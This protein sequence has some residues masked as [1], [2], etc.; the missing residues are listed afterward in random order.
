MSKTRMGKRVAS[1]LLSLV[2][3]LSLLPTTVYAEGADDVATYDAVVEETI[4]PVN[5]E[6]VDAVA[7]EAESSGDKVSGED[8]DANVTEGGGTAN[9]RE[10]ETEYAAFSGSTY[11]ATLQDAINQGPYNIY[12]AKDVRE[13]FSIP[14]GKTVNLSLY[15]HQLHGAITNDGSL[16]IDQHKQYYA[17]PDIGG[18]DAV[19]TNNGTL[20]LACDGATAF[21]V[22]N[23][24]TLNITSGA[25]YSVSNITNN[26]DG[27]ITISGGYF[28]EAPSADWMPAYYVAKQQTNGRYK[29]V[30]M[31][32]ADAIAAGY[33]A[34][35][36]FNG[37]S[38]YK[39]VQE[40]I[41][42]LGYSSTT[43]NLIA[44]VTE[45]C[46]KADGDISLSCVGTA[47]FTGSL[48]CPGNI[49]VQNGTVTLNNIECKSFTAQS[50]SWNN[51]T[52][53]T[54]KDGT[55]E[56]VTVEKTA[57]NGITVAIEGGSYTGTV[58]VASEG[59]LTVTGGNF[60][61]DVSAYLADGYTYD[62][63]TGTVTPA[64]TTAAAKIGETTYETLAEAFAAAKDGD[65]ITLLRDCSGDGIGVKP[66]TFTS[67][68]L[69]VDFAGHT[70][71]VG[72]KLV[73]SSGTMSNGFQL[74]KNNK[75]TFQNGAIY[76][77]AS[78]AGDDTTS[79]S[80][81]PAIL[82]Q[83]Y[84]D[85][86]LS[87]MK[88]SGGSNTVY[89]M[90]NN[91]GNVVIENTTI[92]AG[93]GSSGRAPFALDACGY[94][95]YTGVSVTVKGTSAINGDIEVSRGAKNKN[96]VTLT[97]E[98][99]TVNGK[100]KIDSSI[101]SGDATTVT[102]SNAVN[103]AAPAG[104]VWDNGTLAAAV[105]QI[106]E[107]GYASLQAAID[108]AKTGDT[109]TLLADATEDVTINKNITLDLG[110]KTL[111]NTNAGKATI[112]VTGGTVTVK[113]GTVIGGTSYYNIEV[114]KGSNANLTLEG[115]TATAGN[116]GSSMIDNWGTL[117][118]ESGDY[119]GGMNTV[120]SEEGSTLTINGGTFTC[121]FGK[122]WSYTAVILVYGDTTINGGKFIQKTTNTSS[123]AKV[124]M[125]G[126]EDGYEA[127]TKVTGGEF[128]NEKL[129]GIFWALGK[130]TPDNFEVSGGTFNKFVSDSFFKEG[131]FAQKNTDGTYGVGG[132]AVAKVNSAEGYNT[133]AEAI[134]AAKAGD[135][136][137]LLQNVTVDK[138]I[139]VDKAITLDLGGKTLTSTW[140]MPSD[141]SG[142]DRYALVNNAKMTLTNGTFA[143]DQARAI[144]AYAGL[145]LN[146]VIVSQTM[147]G[148]HACVAFCKA[149]AT[150]TIKS[151]TITGDY[152]VANFANNATI[153]ITNSTKL[154]G[155]TCGLYHNGSNYGLKLTVINTTINGSLDGTIGNENDPSGVYISGSASHGTMQKAT[156]TNC[157][158]KGATAIEVKYTDLT[159][160]K[161]TV[162]AT[163]KTPSY[164]KNNNGMTALG[165]AVVSTDNSKDGVTPVPAGTVTIKGKGNYTGLVGLGALKSVK[166]TYEGFTD[167]TIKVS[168][169]TF[170]NTVL[171]EYCADGFIPT[172]NADG[173]YGV[174]QGTYVAET[175]GVKYESL[176]EAITAAK[177]GATVKL[178]ADTRENVTIAND[179]TLDLNGHT[180]NGGTE[181][182][183]PALTV[184]ASVNVMTRV[185]V[186]DSSEAQT[187][188]IM[189]EDTAENSGVSSHYVIDIQGKCVL[190][191]E[192]GNVKN[193]SGNKEGKGASLVRVG[194]DSNMEVTPFLTIT[195]G[196]FTQNNFIAIKVDRGI[197]NLSGGEVNSANSYAVE[198]WCNANIKGGIVNGT[199]STW[200]YSKGAATSKLTIIDGTVK[201]DVASVNYDS[202][203]DKQARVFIEGG[204]V[205]GTLGTYT[206]NNG[207][208]A[209][210]ETS[211]ATIKV[212]GGTFANA[213]E[214]Q[215]C[216][217]GYVP[218]EN[219]DNTYGVQKQVLAKIG[220]I[221]YYTMG[222]AFQAVREGETIVMQRDY[223]TGAEQSS[224]NK[225]FAIDLNGKTWTYTGT[226][227]NHAAFEINYPNVTL[228]V[229]N[230]TVVSN[231]M[232]GLIPSAM[233]G[234]ITYD[235]AGLVFE[236]VKMTAKGHSGI[237]TNGSN[238]SDTVT[239][240]NSTL[241]VPNGFGIY[242]PSSGKLTI[243]NS[244]ITAKTMGVQVCAGSLSISGD[245]T[246]ITV[247]GDAV[248]KTENDG[249]IQD[250]AAISIVNRT[251]YKGLGDVT[252]TGGTFTAKTGNEAIKAYDWKNNTESE[253]ADAGKYIN[254][255][256]GTFSSIP[257]NM[258]ALCEDG[259]V[260]VKNA[261]G[262]AVQTGTY[263]ASI[264]TKKFATLAEAVEAAKNGDTVK[265]LGDVVLG[266]TLII[267]DK[268]ITLDLNGRIISNSADIWDESK[269]AWSLI[270][271]RDKGNLTIDD[272]TG[273][274]TL[275][276][277]END[278]F[279]LDVYAYDTK[280]VEN[281]KLTINA[282]N[283]VGNISAVYAFTGKATINGGHF[284]I[285]QKEN[286]SDPYRLTLNCYD[287]SYTAGRAGFTVNGGTFENFDPRNNKAEGAG[288]S[289]V[290]EGVGVNNENGTF[291][292]V[293]NMAAQRIAADGSSV[294]AYATLADAIA[295]AQ[296]GQTVMLLA[297]VNGNVEIAA[298]KNLTLDLNGK[299]LNGGTGT[300]KAA[301]RNL[302]TITI[303]DTSAD[304]TGTIKRDDNGT[305]GG[306]SYYVIDNQGTMTIES[307][308]VSNNSGYRKTNPS[309]SMVGSSLIRNG[310]DTAATLTITGGTLEQKNFIAIKNGSLGTLNVSGGTISSDHSAIQNWFVANIT[311]GKI[312]GQLWTD[313][314]EEGESVGKTT[315]GENAKFTGEIVMDITGSVAPELAIT[316]GD[317]DVTNWRITKA[318]AKAGAK[319]AVSGGTF[320]S[321]VPSDYCAPGYVPT[322]EDADGRYTVAEG[323]FTVQVTSRTV[324][325]N[326]HVANVS[327]GGSN[328]TYAVG[329]TVTAASLSGYKFVGWFVNEYTGTP[330]STDLTCKVKPTD[331][332]TMIAVYEPI[333]GGVFALKVYASRFTINDNTVRTGFVLRKV[334]I[335]TQ[336]TVT[337]KGN[338]GENFLY[339]VNES[340][341]VVSTKPAYTF[342]MGSETTLSA[343]YGAKQETQ[344]MVV[345]V[346]HTQQVIS[347]EAYTSTQDIEFPEPPIKMG[348]TFLRWSMTQD[349]IHAAMETTETGIITVE[350]V[351]E[352]TTNTYTVTIT[353]P[354]GTGTDKYT[355]KIG[356]M[357][358]I[359][360]AKI[361]GMTF[362]CWK[363]GKTVLG[364]T[365]TL[366]VAPRSDLSLTAE[367]VDSSTSV[368]RLPVIT[369]TEISASQQ[370]QRYAVS[371]T[372]T[373]SVPNDYTVTEQGVLVSTNSQYGGE[374]ALE[375]FKLDADGVK[376]AGALSLKG[377]NLDATGV[378]VLNGTTKYPERIV[379]GRAYMILR[380]NDTGE[381]RYIYSDT[382]RSGSYNSLTKGGN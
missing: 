267:K 11:Y 57:N 73:G 220:E 252:V 4:A 44:P 66:G 65:T 278:C 182:G 214:E 134:A 99:G 276:A 144:G 211:K 84:C 93:R 354:E 204:T 237:E 5:A 85:L 275:K 338:T 159:L 358:A 279:A 8:G 296:D 191:F 242:F 285:Q 14:A 94:S 326:T 311:G 380:N 161:C 54:I 150:Y 160:N 146:N 31:E 117:T 302:G 104:Y 127:T 155:T 45:N 233:G 79:W 303:R 15:G 74:N 300:A 373:R 24:G 108:A 197:L 234:T 314:W 29:V 47:T 110:G 168:G 306:T 257:A 232:V 75:I 327:G 312:N 298:G 363:N 185:T 98:S 310:D 247:S 72:G 151:S 49:K 128:N 228:T 97:L 206:Y 78:V 116:T 255:S 61:S 41:D 351:Y 2:M 309:G 18:G 215:Y 179:L 225:R 230:G 344:A 329:T 91:C 262:Y 328:I 188:I 126:K 105:A 325:S 299:I 52:N 347:S 125:T 342:I 374:N 70:Y 164:D 100:L 30:A 147:T 366:K 219:D 23:Y 375:T 212:S 143:A 272:T 372:A 113:N 274:G 308:T 183:K 149:G 360:A 367:Y 343:V 172:A 124:V 158:I 198:N 12:L 120:K 192:S 139:S 241:D 378:T 132:P 258:T 38:Y 248:P 162:E 283:Y 138:P 63:T 95:D 362:K 213:V 268:T 224:G 175:N 264:G 301:L 245:Q 166:E 379:Y 281:T 141:A 64:T 227:T 48:K 355:T 240:K 320:S 103:V 200:V 184:K 180:L 286:G 333:S 123:Y 196:T 43:I 208:V 221:S 290:A 217:E 339:W 21:V 28:D 261:D 356:E 239:L 334:N 187:G 145:T 67:K 170:N 106:G 96:A 370:G 345:F 364:Y 265:L 238:T 76:G 107:T 305:E 163:V 26:A 243:D 112:S 246:A 226:N 27:K 323:E 119:S 189:R 318:A 249:A 51:S 371:F 349:E 322:G 89:T 135:T 60:T 90:S 83:N 69:T 39:T 377:T 9:V 68:G 376:P 142:A 190:T 34:K 169:G 194:D 80:G 102:K 129:S 62:N 174:K 254:V 359:T 154:N 177:S 40:A 330:Y 118:I 165:F 229:K 176:A 231:S 109:V 140:A 253:W 273:G 37:D 352:D 316:G 332:C 266:E 222:E 205:T 157:T 357:T 210:N 86:T 136:V 321:K 148:G 71:T 201:G 293:P 36:S 156:F 297:D 1:L 186:K 263:V 77:D 365:E 87:G 7:Q 361:E 295:A 324:S 288:T 46:V 270:S 35:I 271:V 218:V 25:T 236:N 336:V 368:E 55:V 260:P 346:S 256:G 181:K 17:H 381:M 171:P 82:I 269:Y 235:N 19:I 223:T 340:N 199:V 33:V 173:T 216:A 6:G 202:A 121:D 382:I 133:L 195:G 259:F 292:A 209:T 331:D 56:N 131:Y 16:T 167:N 22:D 350:P 153:S 130:A 353:Y 369:L 207:L 307:G 348:A 92:N 250:G 152:A 280:N 58:T 53:V 315:I 42:S 294:E 13:E 10:G 111:T 50:P 137:T 317:L 203:A 81:A 337:F 291:T 193:N 3:M 244:T 282:G 251:G 284:S 277:K 115:V 319:P 313:A 101:K 59:T 32:N 287:S 304:K 122:K 20:K 335:G 341:K 114:T 289:F 88:V 178:L